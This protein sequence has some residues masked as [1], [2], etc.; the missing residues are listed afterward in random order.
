MRYLL[1]GKLA[2]YPSWR[3]YFD[4]VIVGGSKP[5]FFTDRNP[6][7]ELDPARAEEVQVFLREI[8]PRY[9]D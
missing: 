9:G 6:F 8:I 7:V 2:N 4:I 5:E 1:D 3:R